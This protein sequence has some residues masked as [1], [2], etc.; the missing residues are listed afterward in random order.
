MEGGLARDAPFPPRAAVTFGV[1]DR[2]LDM[3]IVGTD[4]L[5]VVGS[6][7]A[8]EGTRHAVDHS[9]RVLCRTTRARFAWP[10]LSWDDH[11]GAEQT[12]SLC[13][14]VRNAQEAVSQVPAYPGDAPAPAMT[15]TSASTA[16]LPWQPSLGLFETP[17]LESDAS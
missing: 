14:Q 6:A 3:L 8:P 12:C 7:G 2:L 4:R 5:R 17:L 11:R 1:A 16:L 15:V 13:T 10:A 9:G